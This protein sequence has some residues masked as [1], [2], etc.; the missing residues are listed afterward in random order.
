MNAAGL[1]DEQRTAVAATEGYVRV[2][3][4]AGSGKTRALSHR[5]AYLVDELGVMPGHILCVTFSNKAANEMRA[6]IRNLTGDNDTG[7]V[8]T[9]HGFCVGVLREDGHALRYPKN[10][11]VLD[12][13]DIDTILRAIYEERGLTLRDSTFAAARD[14]FEIRKTIT[15]PGYAALVL[16][17]PLADLKRRYDEASSRDDILFYGYLYH[18]RKCFALDYNDLILFTL[19]LFEAEPDIRRKWQ[20]R[21][22]YIMVDEFQDIDPLQYRLMKVLQEHHRNLFVVGDP[23]QT[24]YSWRGADVRFLLDFDRHFA[25]A[26]TILM[27]RNYRS[28]PEI[29]AVVNSLI[30]KNSIRMRKELIPMR[31]SGPR[32]LCDLAPRQ[33]AEAAWIAL[34]M[35]ELHE[36]ADAIPYAS[37]AVLYRAH[38]VTREL[39]AALARAEIPYTI[40]S[41]VQ[42]Y[43]R[44][45]VKDALCYLRLVACRDDISFLRVA[46]VPRRNLGAR[47][48][49]FLKTFAEE[50]H[51][52]LYEALSRSI[53]ADLFRGTG[54]HDL[55]RLVESH[56]AD[57]AG[58]NGRSVSELLSALL[59][60]SGYERMLRTEGSQARL[61]NLA[62]LKR[63]IADYELSVGEECTPA[64]FLAHVA[65]F[66][67]RDLDGASDRVKLMTVHTAKG[68]EFPY[69]F[70]CS[71]NEGVFPSQ[72]TATRE[73]MEEERRLA[74]VAMTRAR[75]GLFLSAAGGRNFDGTPRYPS[76]FLLD[77]DPALF[78][79]VEPPPETLVKSVRLHAAAVDATLDRA[80]PAPSGTGPFPV[81]AR[82]RHAVFGEGTVEEVDAANAAYR[83]RFDSLPTPR[84][85]SFRITLTP[86]ALS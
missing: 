56:A 50:N 21:L 71:M 17:H 23:D 80:A 49:A 45:E 69:V 29:V 16:E 52:T 4:G 9:F 30:G 26:K 39:E 12:N 78:D 41:G 42:F 6:R 38:Y 31:P 72:K 55:L 5:F 33:D 35:K 14:R 79:Y 46:N 43:D 8:N 48:M 10:F 57:A 22:E 28:S 27:N 13:S 24:I 82:V 83:I 67:N 51:C 11:P 58:G 73:Q 54:A 25:P 59:D 60:E 64:D 20:E 32:V 81:G 19:R 76:R 47:R 36:G 1:N 68:L 3:A 40:Y 61:D 75:R 66:T 86:A 18:A 85:L 44:A 84:T 37:M 2:V 77:I 7:L 53:D 65:L 34:K 74:F 15:E 70:L 63:G 62:E